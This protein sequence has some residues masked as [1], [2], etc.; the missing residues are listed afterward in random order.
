MPR[1]CCTPSGHRAFLHPTRDTK[2]S[3]PALHVYITP[4]TYVTVNLEEEE[5]EEEFIRIQWIL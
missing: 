1:E 3:G 2:V 4:F 5:E